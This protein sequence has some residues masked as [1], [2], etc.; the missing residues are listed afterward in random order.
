MNLGQLKAEPFENYL[1]LG[2][3]KKWLDANGGKPISFNVKLTKN[4][5]L[6]L[7]ANLENLS[8]RTNEV[9]SNEN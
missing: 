8:K 2:L 5:S 3:S 1:I 9:D 6:V 7:L 4:G